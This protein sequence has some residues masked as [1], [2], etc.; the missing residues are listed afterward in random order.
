MDDAVGPMLSISSLLVAS[1]ALALL[2]ILI[3]SNKRKKLL[4]DKNKAA[5][6][7]RRILDS[8]KT[9]RAVQIRP[10]QGTP[11]NPQTQTHK[12][13]PIPQFVC[14]DHTVLVGDVLRTVGAT[15]K[16]FMKT[17]SEACHRQPKC[18]H[19]EYKNNQCVL[20][21]RTVAFAEKVL[22]G[23]D[24]TPIFPA[25]GAS[26]KCADGYEKGRRV[27][28]D[29]VAFQLDAPREN[30]ATNRKAMDTMVTFI[31]DAH[32]QANKSSVWDILSMV[33]LVAT[34][35]FAPFAAFT[36]PIAAVATAVDLAVFAVDTATGTYHSIKEIRDQTKFVKSVKEWMK[37]PNDIPIFVYNNLPQEDGDKLVQGTQCL[38]AAEKRGS[39]C[40]S[41]SSVG[42]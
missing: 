29:S 16:D 4:V 38:Q 37:V 23:L 41:D 15:D 28:L 5:G 1:C 17:C 26:V 8:A 32:A 20:K 31:R 2:V 22:R 19:F 33:F 24:S 40:H 21:D 13:G 35:V 34:L 39:A 42:S 6:N 25:C 18:T 12:T 11:P 30:G 10:V 3:F 36:G 7:L 14:W 9:T 27:C